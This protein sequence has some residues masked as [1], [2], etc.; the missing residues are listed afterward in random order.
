M[1][2]TSALRGV[3]EK[4]GLENITPGFTAEVTVGTWD[5]EV[6]SIVWEC[7]IGQPAM[8]LQSDWTWL[9]TKNYGTDLQ[10]LPNE[11]RFLA[12]KAGWFFIR[13]WAQH[14]VWANDKEPDNASRHTW[15]LFCWI[16]IAENS[17]S[18][19]TSGEGTKIIWTGVTALSHL[20]DAF[21]RQKA[22]HSRT[23]KKHAEQLFCKNTC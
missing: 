6:F 11:L 7:S 8:F 10:F 15:R 21:L 4:V 20:Q 2:W 18:Q 3:K 22:K 17:F 12:Q 19:F 5:L 14:L 1:S 13:V 23:I 16:N 9:L